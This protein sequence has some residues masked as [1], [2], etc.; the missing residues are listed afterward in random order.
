MKTLSTY[1]TSN[2]ILPDPILQPYIQ[3]YIHTQVNGNTSDFNVDLFPVGYCV[4]SI[5]LDKKGIIHIDGKKITTQANITGQLNQ[6][7][8]MR[9]HDITELV[10]IMFKP[11][12]TYR[13]LQ[14][15]QDKLANTFTAISDLPITGVKELVNDIINLELDVPKII[16]RIENWLVMLHNLPFSN[17]R[18]ELIN[19]IIE[20]IQLSTK[21]ITLTNLYKQFKISNRTLERHFKEMIGYTP[22]EYLNF[23]RF[24]KAYEIIKSGGS[25]TWPEIICEHGY[26]D[27]SHFIKEFKKKSGYTPNQLHKSITNIASHVKDKIAGK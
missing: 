10:Y 4:I 22:K 17:N 8:Q 27:Q 16:E 21:K 1:F 9:V 5:S 18:F 26:F 12:G 11:L 25:K 23:I 19:Q 14:I 24:N 13:I 15:P 20:N 6:H 7:Y 2:I 3:C